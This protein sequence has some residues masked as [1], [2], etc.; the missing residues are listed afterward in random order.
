MIECDLCKDVGSSIIKIETS[1]GIKS[2]VYCKNCRE[3]PNYR[4]IS[5][6]SQEEI[7]LEDDPVKFQS[8][9]GMIAQQMVAN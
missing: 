3:T 9:V 6:S 7:R 5:Q 4:L 1:K 8:E 2:F